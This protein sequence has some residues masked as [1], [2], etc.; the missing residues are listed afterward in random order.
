MAENED[1]A[2]D[3]AFYQTVKTFLTHKEP[4]GPLW[5]EWTQVYG[6]VTHEKVKELDDLYKII[7][8]S[9]PPSLPER[10]D[11]Y[12]QKIIEIV[13]IPELSSSGRSEDLTL[14]SSAT[15]FAYLTRFATILNIIKKKTSIGSN[16]NQSEIKEQFRISLGLFLKHGMIDEEFLKIRDGGHSKCKAWYNAF[17][18]DNRKEILKLL[19]E[20]K[21]GNKSRFI[22]QCKEIT[23]TPK[24]I[25]NKLQMCY[26]MNIL[27]SGRRADLS[28]KDLNELVTKISEI[29]TMR[30]FT[31]RMWLMLCTS[32]EKAAKINSHL[33]QKSIKLTAHPHLV[34]PTRFYKACIMMKRGVCDMT[35]TTIKCELNDVIELVG[36]TS[37]NEKIDE[38]DKDKTS[39]SEHLVHMLCLSNLGDG[40]KIR[41][42]MRRNIKDVRVIVNP[43]G[44]DPQEVQDHLNL[45]FGDDN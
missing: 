13:G 22:E 30:P 42:N 35:L 15:N 2:N 1:A 38:N 8:N 17:D 39:R 12:N 21:D 4:A 25:S 33:Y 29:S 5:E 40:A 45:D 11:A 37:M 27:V 32:D 9:Q 41:T 31:K 36:K 16:A 19:K 43:A 23:D 24:G 14:D 18:E 26:P 28:I 44:E 10:L 7:D 34:T 6:G 20:S 3:R